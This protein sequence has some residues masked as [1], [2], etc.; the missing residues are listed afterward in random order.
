MGTAITYF[1]DAD[2]GYLKPI[3]TMV[4]Q[5]NVQQ[6]AFSNFSAKTNLEPG[7]AGEGAVAVPTSSVPEWMLKLRKPGGNRRKQVKTNPIGRK[8]VQAVASGRADKDEAWKKKH[9]GKK[10]KGSTTGKPVM[11]KDPDTAAP[12]NR[13][14]KERM[15]AAAGDTSD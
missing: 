8:G 6:A 14:K 9:H 10:N 2:V 7:V 15:Q 3:A 12:R 5:S 4:N 13:G 11:R 1:T